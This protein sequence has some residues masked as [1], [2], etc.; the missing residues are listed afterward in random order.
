MA[1]IYVKEA[2]KTALCLIPKAVGMGLTKLT[3]APDWDYLGEQAYLILGTVRSWQL[4]NKIPNSTAKKLL[5]MG[6]G[7]LGMYL[8]ASNPLPDAPNVIKDIMD[9]P[10]A[11]YDLINNGA[12]KLL[13]KVHPRLAFGARETL[14][15][16]VTGVVGLF[17]KK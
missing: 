16:V 6:V 11:G 3:G 10:S 12:N 9:F 14:A 13:E 17:Y 8:I 1:N 7:G 5:K 4:L 15:S 2:G